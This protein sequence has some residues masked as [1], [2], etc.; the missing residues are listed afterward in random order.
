[1]KE[2]ITLDKSNPNVL[3]NEITTID[4]ALTAPGW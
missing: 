3:V 2:W 1:V 4:K